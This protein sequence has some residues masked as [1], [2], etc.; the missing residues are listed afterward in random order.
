M[1]T[2]LNDVAFT[3]YHLFHSESRIV[4]AQDAPGGDAAPPAEPPK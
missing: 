3:D 2:Q 4:P 1:Q